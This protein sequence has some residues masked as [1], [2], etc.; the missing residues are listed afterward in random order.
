MRKGVGT[1]TCPKSYVTAE[2]VGW[3]EE[4]LVR[5]ELGGAVCEEMSARK[6]EAFVVLARE[7]ERERAGG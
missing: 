4:F 5:R 1:G 2:S 6:V 7:L 3:I